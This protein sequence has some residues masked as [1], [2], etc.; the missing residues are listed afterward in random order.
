[1]TQNKTLNKVADILITKGIKSSIRKGMEDAYEKGYK[2]ATTEANKRIKEL[3]I[4][5]T[6]LVAGVKNWQEIASKSD[7]RNAELEGEGEVEESNFV[8]DKFSKLLAEICLTLKGE[9]PYCTRF[10]YHDLPKIVAEFK[11]ANAT[12][13]WYVRDKNTQITELQADNERL[14]EIVGEIADG[15][16]TKAIN[17]VLIKDTTILRFADEIKKALSAT[18]AQSVTYSLTANS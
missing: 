17:N 12:A 15:L 8:I 1:M 9:P 13:Q 16:T 18:Q 7:A 2:A 14:R 10:S 5:N 3:E 6:D 4:R 11:S